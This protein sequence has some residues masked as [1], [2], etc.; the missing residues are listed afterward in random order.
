MEWDVVS[1]L[2]DSLQGG[3]DG[4]GKGRGLVGIE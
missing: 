1:R 3:N 4:M 2:G